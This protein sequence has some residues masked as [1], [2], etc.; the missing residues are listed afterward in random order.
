MK[1]RADKR[2]PDFGSRRRDRLT[3][4]PVGHRRAVGKNGLRVLHATD[5]KEIE[6]EHS[7]KSC[8]SICVSPPFESSRRNVRSSTLLGFWSTRR[9]ETI[10]IFELWKT[11]CVHV[12]MTICSSF[13][14]KRVSLLKNR[15]LKLENKSKLCF[16]KYLCLFMRTDPYFARKS[17]VSLTLELPKA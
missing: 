9:F 1:A 11:V 13:E 6:A 14:K 10:V 4:C 15:S 17:N 5:L 7:L 2:P 3:D 12:L 16:Y 8:F